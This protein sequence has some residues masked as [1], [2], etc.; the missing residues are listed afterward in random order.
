MEERRD[1]Y[2]VLVGN[3]REREH[4]KTPNVDGRII[5]KLI[6]EKWNGSECIVSISFRIG[7][8]GGLL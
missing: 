1:A 2:K 3:L 8:G 5:L 7:A 4:L 6:F